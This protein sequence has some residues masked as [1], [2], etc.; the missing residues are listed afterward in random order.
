MKSKSTIPETI[1]K[2][3]SFLSEI[4]VRKDNV[5]VI[6]QPIYLRQD[7]DEPGMLASVEVKVKAL[8]PE[9]GTIVVISDTDPPCPI[10]NQD[11]DYVWTRWET[12]FLEEFFEQL[13]N[14]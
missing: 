2:I 8:Y 12:S 7:I 9:N 6:D 10:I 11:D 1:R 4:G 13:M 3:S 14:N 5:L